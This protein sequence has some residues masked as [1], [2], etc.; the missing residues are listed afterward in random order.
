MEGSAPPILWTPIDA[1]NSRFVR[2]LAALATQYPELAES[3]GSLNPSQKYFIVPTADSLQLG[4]GAPGNIAP[5]THT[6]PPS[7]ATDMLQKMYPAAACNQPAVIVGE[8]MGWLWNALYNLPC[9]TP[10]A[11]GHRPP[12]YFLIRDLDR[13]WVL[14]HIHDWQKLLA[15]PRVRLFTG[16]S[17]LTNFRQALVADAASPWPKLCVRVDPSLWPGD[18]TLDQI[19]ADAT[20]QT[21]RR[22]LDLTSGFRLAYA[23]RTPEQIVSQFSTGS[24]LKILGIT[25]RFTTFL[26]Y[27]MRDWL[28]AFGRL[29]HQTRL[30][31]E[32]HDHEACNGL[33]I[34]AACA[35]FLPDLVVI[36]DHYRGELSGIPSQIPVVMWVQDALPHIYRPEAGRAQARLDYT[37][38]YGRCELITRHGYPASRFMPAMVGV[39]PDR[40][41]AS[42]LGEAELAPYRCDV[43]FVSHA[44][45][46][47]EH[48]IREETARSGS[49]EVKRLL[50][51]IFERLRAIYDAGGS[52][53]A[54]EV[55]QHLIV[56]TMRDLN[57]NGD[58][59]SFLDLF[60]RRVNN[61]LFRH[62]AIRWV[63]EMDVDLRLY[64]QG[65]ETHPEF[66][67]F[68]RGVADNLDQLRIIYQATAI[69]LQVTPFGAVHQRLL[70][71]L[72]AGGFFL[73]RS[74]TGDELELVIRDM[75]NWCRRKQVRS[76]R[77][78]LEQRDEDLC[79]LLR[80]YFELALVD[81]S[82]NADYFYAGFE[83]CA[84]TGFT[85]TA[86]TLFAEHDRVTFSTREQLVRQVSHFLAAPGERRELARSMR[87]R[88]LETH[89]YTAITAR[90]LDFIAAD[91]K[92]I[93]AALSRAA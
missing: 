65:W 84:M 91:L 88:V 25:S 48:F 45:T 76:G 80:R 26:Q 89:T 21:N 36:I 71:G 39:N 6:L 38:G 16:E 5:V 58:V 22:F 30:L 62:Q 9:Q 13:L 50:D 46:P 86:N 53:T 79:R 1:L 59:A 42:A 75:W 18:L 54:G 10:A 73:M 67:R 82:A 4:V 11:P 85:R 29:G 56:S 24:P 14:L 70:D 72:A 17:A 47:P 12:L 74:V 63:A 61:A 49:P 90:M 52:I 40:F 64:G 3:L 43:S 27:S 37:I 60:S 51:A 87:Q 23:N 44:T 32:Q 33:G 8:D 2:N 15:D 66:K 41:G 81:P 55:L 69:N 19:L 57:L 35:E 93:P 83:E 92:Q 34:A 31:I 20:T 78:M 68:A 7:V 28:A 77:E